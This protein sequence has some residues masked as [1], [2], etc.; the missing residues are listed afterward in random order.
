MYEEIEK[1]ELL[2]INS[3]GRQRRWNVSVR[4]FVWRE[5]IY[6][7]SC[8]RLVCRHSARVEM[9][10][11]TKGLINSLQH[12]ENGWR[13]ILD[14]NRDIRKLGDIDVTSLCGSNGKSC[15]EHG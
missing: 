6:P 9:R 15:P 5:K 1:P 12:V 10:D 2:R 4:S 11:R 13:L 7:D 14:R 3:K 8:C